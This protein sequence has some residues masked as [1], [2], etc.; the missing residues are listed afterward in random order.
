MRALETPSDANI[1]RPLALGLLVAPLTGI[2]S[3][4]L[5]YLAGRAVFQG[6]SYVPNSPWETVGGLAGL[7][8]TAVGSSL[9]VRH[10]Q[11]AAPWRTRLV[12]GSI[13]AVPVLVML[14]AFVVAL[15]AFG[16]A[17]V[18]MI[19]VVTADRVMHRLSL[20]G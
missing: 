16:I 11:V 20:R 9:V 3:G 5:I 17:L 18:V 10:Y 2:L 19:L 7:L 6:G 14:F 1:G 4:A 12:I 13:A 8:V 15:P